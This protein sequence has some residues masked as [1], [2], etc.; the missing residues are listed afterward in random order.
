MAAIRSNC[1]DHEC[2]LFL[3]KIGWLEFQSRYQSVW[4]GYLYTEGC[5]I[6]SELGEDLVSKNET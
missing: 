1:I 2:L 3:A 5:I 4:T 6:W